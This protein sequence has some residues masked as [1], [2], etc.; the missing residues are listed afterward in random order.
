MKN[1]T[2]SVDD[3]LYHEAR[4]VAAQRRKTV[5]ALVREFLAGLRAGEAGAEAAAPDPAL[6][7]LFAMS[8]RKHKARRGSAG[9]VNREEIYTRGIPRH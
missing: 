7:R 3:A 4:V 2:V 6:A 9:P 5:S 8:D 1:I